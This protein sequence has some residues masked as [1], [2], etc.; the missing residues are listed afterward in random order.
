MDLK[1][2]MRVR[3]VDNSFEMFGGAGDAIIQYSYRQQYGSGSKDDFS[4]LLLDENG[5]GVNTLAWV[6]P[7]EVTF[8]NFDKQENLAKIE[9]YRYP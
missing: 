2:G 9:A 6:K 3:A 4:V 5:V 7:K 1:R 8:V